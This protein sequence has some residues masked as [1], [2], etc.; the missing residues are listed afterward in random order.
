MERLRFWPVE[1]F[2]A[3]MPPDFRGPK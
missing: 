3:L 1:D 2:E